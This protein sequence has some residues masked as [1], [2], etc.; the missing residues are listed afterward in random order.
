[1]ENC[2]NCGA[3]LQPGAQRCTRCGSVVA[4]SSVDTAPLAT[5]SVSE[6]AKPQVIYVQAQQ[7]PAQPAPV[8]GEKSKIVAFLLAWFLGGFGF[9]KFYLGRIGSGILYFIFC[10]TFIPAIIAFFE[11]IG[12]LI[13][14]DEAFARKYG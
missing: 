14:S 6:K 7:A 12:Y 9:H 2:P 8:V 3:S 1:M 11:G 13:S 10:W 5:P 4:S